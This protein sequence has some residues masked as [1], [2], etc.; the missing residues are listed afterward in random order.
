MIVTSV[1]DPSPNGK[2]TLEMVNNIT[3]NEEA[4]NKDNGNVPSYNAYVDESY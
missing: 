2:L 4:K 1:S 3:L